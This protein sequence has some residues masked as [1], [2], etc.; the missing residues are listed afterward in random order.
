MTPCK[1]SLTVA[2]RQDIVGQTGD[3]AECGGT[4]RDLYRRGDDKL[5]PT[6]EPVITDVA[7]GY[8]KLAR[9]R[10]G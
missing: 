4:F 5:V 10:K 9:Q 6:H 7:L 3:C 1:G 2:I 8:L